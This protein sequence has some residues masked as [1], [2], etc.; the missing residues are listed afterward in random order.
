MLDSEESILSWITSCHKSS[1]RDDKA[2]WR[3]IGSS[4]T[5]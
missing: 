1:S 3:F 4:S 5:L 2:S